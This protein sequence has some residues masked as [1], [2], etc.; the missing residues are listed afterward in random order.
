MCH[1]GECGGHPG[2]VSAADKMPRMLGRARAVLDAASWQCPSVWSGQALLVHGAREGLAALS[3]LEHQAARTFATLTGSEVASM[4]ERASGTHHAPGC[5]PGCDCNLC[6]SLLPLAAPQGA[7]MHR[8][9]PAAPGLAQVPCMCMPSPC[10]LPQVQR[11]Q[12]SSVIPSLS[13]LSKVCWQEFGRSV[14]RSAKLHAVVERGMSTVA[15]PRACTAGCRCAR[16]LRGVL[17]V[18]R[19]AH[20]LAAAGREASTAAVP[21]PCVSSCR[22]EMCRAR[23]VRHFGS[24]TV[25]DKTQEVRVLQEDT[26]MCVLSLQAFAA[27]TPW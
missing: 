1:A 8:V 18:Q 24:A 4:E 17:S 11:N 21:R 16:C 2:A 5:R 14:W 22:C 23:G 6:S 3:A 13:A 20:L 10:K 26:H 9:P 27:C 15:L 7:G 25:N 12:H 19:T